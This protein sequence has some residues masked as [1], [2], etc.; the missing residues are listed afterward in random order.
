MKYKVIAKGHTEVYG[1][2]FDVELRKHTTIDGR[3]YYLMADVYENCEHDRGV[4]YDDKDSAIEGFKK[5]IGKKFES[6]ISY[7][8]VL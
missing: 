8:T 5:V 2:E 3:I 6:T 7:E 1:V 4:P